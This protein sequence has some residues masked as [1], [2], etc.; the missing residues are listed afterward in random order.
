[1][2]SLRYGMSCLGASDL[3]KRAL[4]HPN[5]LM[6]LPMSLV[7]GEPPMSEQE[8]PGRNPSVTHLFLHPGT[9]QGPGNTQPLFRMYS[10]SPGCARPSCGHSGDADS[11]QM[12]RHSATRWETLGRGAG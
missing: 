6:F 2:P 8:G 7:L 1:M 4:C 11:Q 12:R 9:V 5:A 10:L 3:S